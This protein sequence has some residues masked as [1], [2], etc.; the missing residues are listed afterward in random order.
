M[1]KPTRFLCRR[2]PPGSRARTGAV[3]ILTAVMLA[4]ILA[5]MALAVDL[6]YVV[7]VRAQLQAAADSAALAG[8][9]QI[10]HGF[11]TVFQTADRYAR[12]HT[13]GGQPLRL[14]RQDVEL[15]IWDAT[16]RTFTP[17]NSAPNAVR[18][19]VR[20]DALTGNPAPLFF[21][22]ALGRQA[23][24]LSAEAI[25]M[26][27]PRDIAFVVDL[28][29]SMNDDTEPAWATDVVNSTFGSTGYGSIGTELMQ[30]V[31]DDF[32]F[33]RF[34]GQLEHIGQ[35]WGVPQ[36]DLAYAELTKD[37]GP[38]TRPNVPPR[39][40]INPTDDEL[41]RKFKAYSAII[42]YQIARVMPNA[43]PAPDSSRFYS[44]WEKYLDY[45]IKPV[46]V[47]RGS[48]PGNDGGDGGGRNGR[49][50]G[51]DRPPPID[52]G[53]GRDR[54]QRDGANNRGREG[55][56]GTSRE[57]RDN[58]SNQGAE[59]SR[60]RGT[61]REGSGGSPGR[62]RGSGNRGGNSGGN[63]GGGGGGSPGSP[64]GGPIGN[65]FPSKFLDQAYAALDITMP[66][67][68]PFMPPQSG[69]LFLLAQSGRGN[70]DFGPN[71][72]E[73]SPTGATSSG[74]PGLWRS[75]PVGSS[76]TTS[77]G[78]NTGGNRSNSGS[79]WLPPNQSADRITGMNNPNR[80]TFPSG[81]SRLP[82]RYL[83]K[84]GYLT[85]VQFM[86]DYGR[87]LKPDGANFVPLS[88]HSPYCPYHLEDT[89]GGTFRFPPREQPTHAARRALIAAIQVVKERNQGIPDP[90]QRDWVSI[91]TYDSLSGG[92]PV[93]A[94]PLTGDYDEAMAV[95]TRLQACGDK[96]AS[97]ATEAGL[98]AARNLLKPRTEG[99]TGRRDTNKVVIL[100]TDGVPNLYVSSPAEI[101]SFIS[102]NP[103]PEY[104]GG[105][106]YPYDAALMQ[107]ARMQ[108]DHWSVFPVGVGLGTDYNFMD[109]LARLGGTAN[110]DGQSPRGSGNPAEYESRLREI[111]GRI[112]ESPKVR[113]VK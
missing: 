100:L 86:M 34:P 61:D 58:G 12:F 78:G 59:N 28:S 66:T 99:G 110:D 84:I 111:F 5:L 106:A 70:R 29:G 23:V 102:Q 73:Q 54:G 76:A 3:L 2:D 94:Q 104:Y 46:Q 91:I 112:I 98:L 72:P 48:S 25:A 50:R 51:G 57:N 87:D 62:G 47:T 9:S 68:G 10:A 40:R 14:L 85:Y 75:T 103:S 52:R 26:A 60:G 101:R 8:A 105:S 95:C 35:P 97:T 56:G 22:R 65:Q 4:V 74:G 16:S 24:D 96:G 67:L 37:N 49:G 36:T 109:R 18:V 69:A 63:N 19:R 88:R 44:Y 30:H 90:S 21:A 6:G 1:R 38:L 83:N 27:N 55:N 32:G 53:D 80:S 11:E 71:G 113:L 79:V 15:G 20:R 13:S 81:S 41:T 31:F 82:E 77:G 93:I 39:Y 7:L 17:T 89:D 92:G 43:R 45:I 108:L 64:G 42:D 107:A 33:G